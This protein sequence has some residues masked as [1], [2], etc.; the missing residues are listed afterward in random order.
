MTVHRS[1]GKRG[2]AIAG[3]RVGV[4]VLDTTHELV[5]GNVQHAA[6]FDFPVLY[7]VVRGISPAELMRGVRS[8]RNIIVKSARTLEAAGVSV[9]VGAC[10][11]F[12]NYQMDTAAAVDVPVFMSI[13]LEVPLILRALPPSRQLGV[14]FARTST[15]TNQV[16]Q[17]CGITEIERIVAIG[18]DGLATFQPILKQAGTLD[19][20]A[21]GTALGDL[22]RA[23]LRR[24]PRIGAWLLQC[25]DLPPYAT[26][27]QSATG[28]PVFDMWTLIY[29]L[30]E[31]S[32]RRR[33]GV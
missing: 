5:P 9:I 21:L 7:E 26:L 14:I 22:A 23:S 31:A 1:S 18:A 6:S 27:I 32:A 24:N 12:A 28:L 13:L 4:L 8:T 3:F 17:Q 16:R 20:A 11:S 15:F 25:S 10:G 19:S 30:F 33:F 29:H 2:R